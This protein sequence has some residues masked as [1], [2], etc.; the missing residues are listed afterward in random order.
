ML[1]HMPLIHP[2]VR[3]FMLNLIQKR[4]RGVNLPNRCADLLQQLGNIILRVPILENAM[5]VGR[6]ESE[7]LALVLI[8]ILGVLWY[9]MVVEALSSDH[10]RL[11]G[12]A[13]CHVFN[14]VAAAAAEDCGNVISEHGLDS[15]RMASNSHIKCANGVPA[16]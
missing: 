1:L 5:L 3:P 12:P 9:H 16:K 7:V 10:Q 11:I 14:T 6:R 4:Q 13:A 15:S 8:F 2:P